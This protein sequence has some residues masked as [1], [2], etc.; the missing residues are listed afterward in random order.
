ME[1]NPIDYAPTDY[2]SSDYESTDY[3]S[4][5][6]EYDSTNSE[7]I[8]YQELQQPFNQESVIRVENGR[9]VHI[10]RQNRQNGL[11]TIS[12]NASRNRR[13][14]EVVTLIITPQT[15]IQNASGRRISLDDLRM[16]MTVNAI[17]SSRMT[18]S[19]PP[20]ALAFL[21]TIVDRRERTLFAEGR[22]LDVNRRN[23]T[24]EIRERGGRGRDGREAQDDNVQDARRRDNEQR[25]RIRFE[26]TDNTVLVNRR[27]REIELRNIRP[28][29][30]V[31]VEY[32]I[33]REPRRPDRNIAVRVERFD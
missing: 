15:M 18:R 13:E 23:G 24:L 11:I 3:E 22:V 16:N 20:Q 29:D 2:E 7:F 12:Y 32:F 33:R 1:Y 27:G 17:F 30:Q 19:I 5:D 21:V 8:D 10:W 6:Y 4:I 9:I 25:N 28:D 26:I 14:E 31:R